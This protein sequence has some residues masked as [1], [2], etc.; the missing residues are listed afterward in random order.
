MQ[1]IKKFFMGGL[2]CAICA[3]II[4]KTSGKYYIPR[5]NIKSIKRLRE[6]RFHTMSSKNI[7]YYHLPKRFVDSYEPL[8][9]D[10]LEW[11]HLS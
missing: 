10:S 6:S 11:Q 7:N 4:N 5:F 9:Y 8:R 1:K 3:R 2:I